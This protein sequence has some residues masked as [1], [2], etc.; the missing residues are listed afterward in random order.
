MICIEMSQ[1]SGVYTLKTQ[2]HAEYAE[3]GK[4]IVCAAVSILVFTLIESIDERD[5]SERSV[6]EQE[7]GKVLV[8][9][10]PKQ[11]TEV[12]IRAVFEVI[13]NGFLLL[14]KNYKKN[15]IFLCVGVRE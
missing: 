1:K 15:I 13:K 6:I 12:K 11:S 7:S 8:S 14:E 3:P 9:V 10:K 4:D 2:G 5:L